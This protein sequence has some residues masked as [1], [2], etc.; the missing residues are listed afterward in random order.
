[1]ILTAM[2]IVFYMRKRRERFGSD[3]GKGV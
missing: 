1:V 3:A 2:G